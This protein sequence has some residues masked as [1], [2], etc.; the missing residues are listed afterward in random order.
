MFP[1]WAIVVIVILLVF[2]CV[3][4]QCDNRRFASTAGF[5]G[6]G[7]TKHGHKYTVKEASYKLIEDGNTTAT[8]RLKKGGFRDLEEKDEITWINKEDQNRTTQVKVTGIH[9]Y[10]NLDE[11]LEK[12]KKKDYDEIAPNKSKEEVKDM[13]YGFY[14]E[15]TRTKH[16]AIL[17]H[18]KKI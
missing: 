10:K 11:A 9:E 8:L 13:Y 1:I 17:I 6:G 2:V 3:Q 18:F 5:Y 12:M 4:N 15:K 16:P 14:D 7:E